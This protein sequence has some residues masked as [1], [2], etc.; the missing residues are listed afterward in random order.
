[1]SLENIRYDA[2]IS[3]RHCELDSFISEHLHKKLESY[4]MPSSAAKKLAAGK[5]SIER[6]FRD[7]AELPLSGNLSDPITVALAHSE[8][9]IV[10]CTP[11]LRQSQWC[12]KE[13]ESFVQ[14]HDREHVLLVLAEGEPE[15]SFP[16]ILL[17][18]EVLAKD[19][20]GNDVTVTIGREPLAADCRGD[21]N[22]QRLKKLDNVVLKLCA[23]MFGLNYDDLRQR[24]RERQVRRR[25]I[26]ASAAFAVVTLFALTC[27]FFTVKI[28]RQN[29]VIQD[30]YAGAMADASASLLSEGL[31]KDAVYAVR[32]VL[33]D[34]ESKAHNADAVYALTEALA[35]YEVANCYFPTGALMIPESIMG[36]DMAGNG[37]CVLINAEG[38]ATL[39]DTDTSREIL[40]IDCVY[41]SPDATG[42]TY[43][44]ED[45][46]AVHTDLKG[47]REEILAQDVLDIYYLQGSK[48]TVLF[49]YEGITVCKD[50]K[51]EQIDI[52]TW[53]S[54]DGDGVE[55]VYRDPAGR[56]IAFVLSAMDGMHAG[57]IDLKTNACTML[58]ALADCEE[59]AIATDGET[60][61]LYREEADMTGRITGS[62]AAMDAGTGE[63]LATRQLSGDGFYKML[64]GEYGLLLVSDRMAYMLGPDLED[65]DVVTG[66]L[67]AVCEYAYEEGFVLLDATGSMYTADLF[68][69]DE[70]AFEL[71]GH[72]DGTFVSHAAYDADHDRFFLH[73]ADTGRISIYERRGMA[74]TVSDLDDATPVIYP[75]EQPDTDGLSGIEDID[76]FCAAL[77]DDGKYIAVSA[78]DGTLYVFDR[79]K[80]EKVKTLYAS[81]ITLWH[82]G[83]I[84]LD[85]AEVYIIG[86]EIFDKDLNR[87][88]KLAAGEI[89]AKGKDGKSVYIRS[90]FKD[91]LYYRIRILP[92]DKLTDLADK[93]LNGYVP[94]DD[95]LSRYSIN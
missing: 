32:S 23:A 13:I 28:S 80:G 73:F 35:P 46:E 41:A 76:V 90:R 48:A 2:F 77:S 4:K 42:V 68:S 64:L 60:V 10:I 49:T 18:E 53:W 7:E 27:L 24:H 94:A 95:V 39:I 91:E 11:R 17:H 58:P 61:Y 54:E 19:A 56:Y 70:A 67:D 3:Y 8:F 71:Y 40:R 22:R 20:A 16:E 87:I 5:R 9:L 93:L 45:G 47:G 79:K 75:E 52:G 69:T 65:I 55:S 83:F 84:Y 50:G 81:G 88:G 62:L 26:A 92:Y 12:M 74:E 31:Q 36:M 82:T 37:N 63:T 30:K 66:Y 72:D 43:L 38:Y 57:L 15:E 89:A 78:T 44:N 86:R 21:N 33:P 85:R 29:K 34:K 25:L 51:S 6:I 1:M 14:M 59:P